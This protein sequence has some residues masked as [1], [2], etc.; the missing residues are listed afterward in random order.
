MKKILFFAVLVLS[1][2]LASEGRAYGSVEPSKAVRG[3]SAWVTY[4]ASPVEFDNAPSYVLVMEAGGAAT[5][6]CQ[7]DGRVAYKVEGTWAVKGRRI[8]FT[9]LTIGETT[10]KSAIVKADEEGP[11]MVVKTTNGIRYFVTL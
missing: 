1:L 11:Y 2:A 8:V 9:G 5:L 4:D 3:L 6:A 7:I 10:Y